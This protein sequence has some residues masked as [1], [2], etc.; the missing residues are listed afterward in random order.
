M[1]QKPILDYFFK[2]EAIAVVGASSREGSIG[3][4]LLDNLKKDGFTG[5]IYP[6]NPKHDEILGYKA[7]PSVTAV[8]SP[9]DLAI[10]AVRS[11]RRRRSCGNAARRR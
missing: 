8:G 3:F 5:P 9:I 11:R 2:P 4:T 6:I 1:L 7:Y 10:I